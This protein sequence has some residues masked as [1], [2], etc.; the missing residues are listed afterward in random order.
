M[1]PIIKINSLPLPLRSVSVI[2]LGL[3]GQLVGFQT[4]KAD[5]IPQGNRPN[6]VFIVTDDQGPWAIGASG[7]S[8]AKTPRIDRLAAEGVRF[9]NAFTPT[10][11]CSPARASIMTSR[12]GSELGITDWINPS[13]DAG[14]GLDATTP[15]WPRMLQQAGYSTA[16]FGKWHLGDTDEQHPTRRGYQTFVGFRGGGTT[17]RD[18][19]LEQG[20]IDQEF[21]VKQRTG[22]IVDLVTD[23]TISWLR[24]RDRSSPFAV[25]IHYR[26]PHAAY[27]PVPDEDWER[28][29]D[30]DINVPDPQIPGLQTERVKKLMRE[31]LA[32][33]AA[34]DRNIG[35]LLDTLDDLKLGS[36]T[37]VIFTSDHGYNLGHHGLLY[38]GNAQWMLEPGAIPPGSE[39]IPRGQ[40]PN[41]FDTSLRVPLVIR[42]PKVV[43]AGRV[44]HRTVSHLDWMPT[45]A[46]LIGH[47]PNPDSKASDPLGDALREKTSRR[48]P[49]A[50]RGR[51]L[52]PLLRGNAA[53]WDNDFYAEYSMK[54]GALA[55]LRAYRTTEW[56]L[57]RDFGNAGRDELYHLASDPGETRNRIHDKVEASQQARQALEEKIAAKMAEISDPILRKLQQDGGRP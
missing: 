26:E 10:P 45:F 56:K 13:Q 25:S 48:S 44:E 37:I 20:S 55:D 33:V 5:E 28:V 35:R 52:L 11:V 3:V 46:A 14:V 41:M 22:F 31:Y 23:E 32:S 27:L 30:L 18:P 8:Q 12:Y 36:D 40:R 38:K 17:P 16:L 39:R 2:A 51:D 47:P 34:I 49:S 57:V 29:R 6:I 53:N 9:T 1:I 43:E 54:H 50:W 19:L 42:W 15:T 24:Q 21:I 4:A 7:M